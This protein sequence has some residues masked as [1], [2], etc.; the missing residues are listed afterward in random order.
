MVWFQGTKQ[1]RIASKKYFARQTSVD[2][3]G[4]A[5]RLTHGPLQMARKREHSPKAGHRERNWD[6]GSHCYY[7]LDNRNVRKNRPDRLF[8]RGSVRGIT[9]GTLI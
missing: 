8:A 6:R 5:V 9:C 3:S 7:N 1:Q 4:V 2:P